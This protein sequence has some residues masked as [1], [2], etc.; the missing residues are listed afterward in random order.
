MYRMFIENVKKNLTKATPLF[1]I[2]A[3]EI[4]VFIMEANS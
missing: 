1:T 2:E 3:K 4:M